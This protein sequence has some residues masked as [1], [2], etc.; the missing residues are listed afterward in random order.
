MEEA[1]DVVLE[2]HRSAEG[3]H[4]DVHTWSRESDTNVPGESGAVLTCLLLGVSG[5]KSARFEGT[6]LT[7][8]R[9]LQCSEPWGLKQR[10]FLAKDITLLRGARGRSRERVQP[11]NVHVWAG[12][13]RGL[14][15]RVD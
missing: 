10:R 1:E 11:R 15:S 5:W 3:V 14:R 13:E 9:L 12:R 8:P 2:S 7:A 6:F 4:A